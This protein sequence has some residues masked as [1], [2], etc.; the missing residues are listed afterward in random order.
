M[1]RVLMITYYWPPAG[2]PGAQRVVKFARYLPEFGWEPIVVTV[3]GGEFPFLDT[4]LETDV[5]AS[6]QIHRTRSWEPFGLY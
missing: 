6:T 4:S 3:D 5:P 1:K 2:G